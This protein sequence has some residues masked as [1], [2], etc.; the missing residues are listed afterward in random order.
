[1]IDLWAQVKQMCLREAALDRVR[2][3]DLEPA[4]RQATENRHGSQPTVEKGKCKNLA[5]KAGPFA[6]RI[7]ATVSRNNNPVL[8][9]DAT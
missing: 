5:A 7:E 2:T 8:T 4:P 3:F 6:L 1:V 9:A